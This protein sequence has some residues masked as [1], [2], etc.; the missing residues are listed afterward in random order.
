[1]HP[2]LQDAGLAD[3]WQ[4]KLCHQLT[5]WQITGAFKTYFRHFSEKLRLFTNLNQLFLTQLYSEYTNLNL[6]WSVLCRSIRAINSDRVK[7]RA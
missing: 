3:N 5:T 4:A 2:D 6:L 1:M 7:W